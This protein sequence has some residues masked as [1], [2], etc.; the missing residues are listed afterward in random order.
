MKA[1]NSPAH[2]PHIPEDS[3]LVLISDVGLDEY[4]QKILQIARLVFATFDKP[5]TQRWVQAFHIAEN[6]FP[7]PF[8]ATIAHAVVITLNALRVSR[9][10]CFS[11]FD[12]GHP[13][14]D[15]VMTQEEKYVLLTFHAIRRKESTKARMQAM[16]A[17]EGGETKSFLS[18]FERLAMITGDVSGSAFGLA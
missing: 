18:A 16:L 6:S 3:G 17:C 9:N 5:E 4:E 14:A 8:G 2:A 11:F 10:R 13:H 1:E 12:A 7:A 15:T